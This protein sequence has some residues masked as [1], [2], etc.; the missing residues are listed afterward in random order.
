M[1]TEDESEW[2]EDRSMETFLNWF[3]IEIGST[4]FDLEKSDLK[5][6]KL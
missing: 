3:D 2:P 6:E 5:G 1:I 4:V